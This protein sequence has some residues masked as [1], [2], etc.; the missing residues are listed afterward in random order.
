MSLTDA[1][2][3][4][5]SREALWDKIKDIRIAMMV[6]DEGDEVLRSRPMYT[7]QPEFDGDIWFFTRDDSAKTDEVAKDKQVNLSY[8]SE[9]NN[10]YVSVSGTAQVVHDRA[11]AEELWSPALKAWFPD[12]LNDPHLALLRVR[13]T[14]AEYWDAPNGVA[15]LFEMARAVVQNDTAQPGENKKLEL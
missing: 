13:A 9:K 14:Q 2:T 3:M 12:G 1:A 15:Q 11:K 7:Q 5:Q 4:T 10:L 8:A 6:T